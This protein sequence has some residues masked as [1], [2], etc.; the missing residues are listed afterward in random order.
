MTIR[1]NSVTDKLAE[2][3][4]DKIPGGNL[5]VFCAGNKMYWQHRPVKPKEKAHLFLQL[6]GIPAVRRHCMAMVS[7]SQL[8]VA[9]KYMRDDIPDVVSNLDLWVRSG[10]E[11]ADAAQKQAIREAIDEL[12]ARLHGVSRKFWFSAAALFVN[13]RKQHLCR[14]TSQINMLSRTVANEFTERLYESY[15]KETRSIL[16]V[17]CPS[18]LTMLCRS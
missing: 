2:M 5:R 18:C 10:A 1:N 7:E 8:R 11:S 6:S 4:R 13:C 17:R 12:E 3:F 16:T 9:L 15:R 14:N